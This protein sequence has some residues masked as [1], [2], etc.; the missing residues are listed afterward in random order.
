M[1]HKNTFMVFE[2]IVLGI[3]H[4]CGTEQDEVA[5]AGTDLYSP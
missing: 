4:V 2:Y 1:P 5:Q 3:I